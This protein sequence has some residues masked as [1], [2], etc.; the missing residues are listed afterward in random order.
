MRLD[1]VVPAYNEQRRIGRT[2]AAYTHDF[3]DPSTRFLAA[4]DGCSD[5]TAEVVRLAQA[6][7]DRIELLEFPKLGKGGVILESFRRAGGDLVAFV[8][9]D[10]ATPPAE[11]R[12]LVEFACHPDADG[13]IASRRLP[14]SVVPRRR[15][16]GR[17]VASHAYVGLVHALFGLDYRDTQCGAKVLRHDALARILPYVSSRDLVFDVDLLLVARGLG[18]KLAEIPTVWIDRDGSRIEGRS[19]S[20]RMAG[21][22][23]R[24]WL[25]HRLSPVA[26]FPTTSDRP[27][28]HPSSRAR[29]GPLVHA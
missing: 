10:C 6:D 27:L 11:L 8:D 23:I 20:L 26:P 22:L 19:D 17:R 29:G 28:T 21:G 4:L 18:L 24:L 9:A 2:L 1:I 7:D 12:R 16:L 5:A 15:P 25:Q 14:A 13:A 3:S